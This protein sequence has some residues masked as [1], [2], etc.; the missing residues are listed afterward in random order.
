MDI[1]L[2]KIYLI[3]LVIISS[4]GLI[5]WAIEGIK[6]LK[7][8][9]NKK[10]VITRKKVEKVEK[11]KKTVTQLHTVELVQKTLRNIGCVPVTKVGDHVDI[12]FQYQGANFYFITKHNTMYAD[13]YYV[14]WYGC[15]L[16][17]LDELSAIQRAVNKTNLKGY[18][19][20]VVYT[21][22]QEENTVGVHCKCEMLFSPEI[23][24]L[25]DYLLAKLQ[26][27]FLIRNIVVEE[28]KNTVKSYA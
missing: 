6:M 26:E 5:G 14:W 25:E 27:S 8:Y 28:I 11:E 16:D 21:I 13:L 19:C 15:P 17:N 9:R 3:A 22:N 7:E 23:T 12:E 2:H 10:K 18:G 24:T 1:D 4:L 20:T